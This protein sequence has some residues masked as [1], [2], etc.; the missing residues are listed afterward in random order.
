MA[1]LN[2]ISI[3]G[4]LTRDAEVKVIPSGTQLL[5]FD[6]ANNTG[7]GQYAKV[8]Y[9]SCNMWGKQG[10]T[11]EKYLIKGKLVAITGTLEQQKWTS[12]QDG[13]EHSKL[14]IN[15]RDCILMSDGRGK[16]SPPKA[17]NDYEDDIPY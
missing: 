12:S 1:D 6:V 13:A 10:P 3:T 17:D 15:V 5:A 14:V 16:D 2:T 4:R 11:L 8:I 9:F 7:F